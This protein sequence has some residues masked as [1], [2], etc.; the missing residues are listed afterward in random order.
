MKVGNY[1]QHNGVINTDP[2][3]K[4]DLKLDDIL[5]R[6]MLQNIPI[7]KPAEL[8]R[9]EIVLS[10]INQIFCL[11]VKEVC[12]S[13]GLSE[14]V[15]SL[16]GLFLFLNFKKII[17]N[18]IKNQKVEKFTHQDHIKLVFMNQVLILML[19]VLLL[20]IAIEKIFLIHLD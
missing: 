7:E 11:W 1:E 2:P 8:E 10:N 15:A 18:L 4:R 3:S 20:N 5:D 13:K 14:E 12:L 19:F 17:S 16:A 9:R 6:F